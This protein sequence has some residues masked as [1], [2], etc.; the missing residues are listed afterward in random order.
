V[1]Q[2]APIA[3]RRQNRSQPPQKPSF[4]S[5]STLPRAPFE[6]L[7]EVVLQRH[8]RQRNGDQIGV[9]L[10]PGPPFR[11]FDE[12]WTNPTGNPA[13]FILAG[14]PALGRC[15]VACWPTPKK[16]ACPNDGC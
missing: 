14:E 7:G 11:F 4:K 8:I 1:D 15:Y 10:D 3:E 6:R 9:C 2:I 13:A 5:A 16:S 12:S